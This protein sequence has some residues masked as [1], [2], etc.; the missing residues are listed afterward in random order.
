[1]SALDSSV[2]EPVRHNTAHCEGYRFPSGFNILYH[3]R[4]EALVTFAAASGS[5][6]DTSRLLGMLTC[7]EGVYRH[8]NTPLGVRTSCLM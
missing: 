3:V 8:D 2:F 4:L 1:V 7:R 6:I 5:C